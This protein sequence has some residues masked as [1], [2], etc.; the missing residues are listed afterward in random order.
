[1]SVRNAFAA[2]DLIDLEVE[3]PPVAPV[4]DPEAPVLDPEA[5]VFGLVP[6]VVGLVPPVVGLVPPVVGLVPPVV[7]L[8][9]PV[10]GLVPPV[11]GLVPPV[12]GL[13][14]PVVGL[15]P[16]VV[17][18]VREQNALAAG[19]ETI[20]LERVQKSID[21]LNAYKPGLIGYQAMVQPANYGAHKVPAQKTPKHGYEDMRRIVTSL[22]A[23]LDSLIED[24]NARA[25]SKQ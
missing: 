23:D 12:V 3:L 13:V 24:Q 8:V 14:P 4:L 9:P 7:G 21:D 19:E 18:P 20:I 11:V 10:V 1:M 6:P 16:P 17:A 25:N 2:G 22:Q 5:P 15:V